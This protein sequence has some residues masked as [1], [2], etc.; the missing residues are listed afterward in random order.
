MS[1]AAT[2]ILYVKEHLKVLV[3]GIPSPVPRGVR[4]GSFQERS[5]ILS[6]PI[7]A[8]ASSFVKPLKPRELDRD[9]AL[10]VR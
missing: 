8:D 4:K 2:L 1:N 9:V 10:V 3:L 5:F 6:T 7:I